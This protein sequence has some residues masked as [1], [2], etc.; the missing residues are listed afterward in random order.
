V[1]HRTRL[2]KANQ[3]RMNIFGI[4]KEFELFTVFAVEILRRQKAC[5]LYLEDR[6]LLM[7]NI[8]DPIRVSNIRLIKISYPV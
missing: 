3:S 2:F 5:W 1:E 8:P 4:F 7:M 6:G